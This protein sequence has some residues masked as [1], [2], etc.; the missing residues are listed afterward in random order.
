MKQA[1]KRV[2]QRYY[3][4]SFIVIN[5]FIYQCMS[6]SFREERLEKVGDGQER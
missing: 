5:H 2:V 6:I 1:K 3:L 4:A